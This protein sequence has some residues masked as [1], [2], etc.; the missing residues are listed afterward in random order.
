MF[1]ELN[2]E[3]A[4]SLKIAERLLNDSEAG[5]KTIEEIK[6][7]QEKKVVVEVLYE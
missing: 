5:K 2:P 3:E 6:K 1:T 7:A 4:E